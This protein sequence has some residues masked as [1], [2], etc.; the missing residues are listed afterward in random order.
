M[1]KMLNQGE[2]CDLRVPKVPGVDHPPWARR[3]DPD[4]RDI[5]R[6]PVASWARG[7]WPTPRGVRAVACSAPADP[8]RDRPRCGAAE[9]RGGDETCA[10]WTKTDARRDARR[11]SWTSL[12]PLRRCCCC[13]WRLHCTNSTWPHW[14]PATR[15]A[16]AAIGARPRCAGRVRAGAGRAASNCHCHCGSGGKCTAHGWPP[17]SARKSAIVWLKWP[18][19]GGT[20]PRRTLVST[21]H[22][23]PAEICTPY[24]YLCPP[25]VPKS[26]LLPFFKTKSI[27]QLKKTKFWQKI[28]FF[29]VKMFTL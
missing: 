16:N 25:P 3:A 23:D 19:A 12:G 29:N 9:G 14:P 2:K 1:K 27:N 28:D 13:W 15:C 17:H 18:A 8:V 20:L 6:L 7:A 5:G 11:S 26:I 21:L 22:C 24:S 10:A 4:C